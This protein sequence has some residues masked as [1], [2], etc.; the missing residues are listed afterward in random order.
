MRSAWLPE[1]GASGKISSSRTPSPC[2]WHG[3][4]LAAVAIAGPGGVQ[5]C[6]KGVLKFDRF[7]SVYSARRDDHGP[8]C[9]RSAYSTSNGFHDFF[10]QPMPSPYQ[11]RDGFTA[12]HWAAMEDEALTMQPAQF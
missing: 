9:K 11:D 10:L 3:K 2:N 12:V 8:A 7:T 5:H 4:A 1:K 6:C